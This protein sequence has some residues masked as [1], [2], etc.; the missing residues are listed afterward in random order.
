MASFSSIVIIILLFIL[1]RAFGTMIITIT[2]GVLFCHCYNG[3]GGEG[4]MPGRML[5]DS[6]PPDSG[7][8]FLRS[9]TNTN[10]EAITNHLFPF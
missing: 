9:R 2:D 5:P 6:P 4:G 1:L 7:G 10:D 8:G 3:G